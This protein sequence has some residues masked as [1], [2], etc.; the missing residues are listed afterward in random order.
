MIDNR[1]LNLG[2]RGECLQEEIECLCSRYQP[3]P[4]LVVLQIW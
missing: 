2:L 3:G 1:I 4:V